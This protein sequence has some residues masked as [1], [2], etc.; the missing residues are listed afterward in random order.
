MTHDTRN[1]I[2]DKI[3]TIYYLN[4]YFQNW[5]LTFFGNNFVFGAIF[6]NKENIWELINVSKMAF[7]IFLNKIYS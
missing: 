7:V 1:F 4:I 6:Y 5:I 3:S 2:I